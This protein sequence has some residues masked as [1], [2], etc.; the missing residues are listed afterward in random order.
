MSVRTEPFD[1]D[2]GAAALLAQPAPKHKGEADHA[3]IAMN[4]R[5]P[6]EIPFRQVSAMTASAF[7]KQDVVVLYVLHPKLVKRR[8][9]DPLLPFSFRSTLP[10][11]LGRR[12]GDA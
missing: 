12:Q 2:L 4:A 1:P 11:G 10:N 7:E 8:R 3:V 5:A 9:H 6:S